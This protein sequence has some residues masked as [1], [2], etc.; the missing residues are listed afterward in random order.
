M[1]EA[2]NSNFPNLTLLPPAVN[3]VRNITNTNQKPP[4]NT[5][6]F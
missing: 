1:S 2:I 6:E 5:T 4:T 3:E